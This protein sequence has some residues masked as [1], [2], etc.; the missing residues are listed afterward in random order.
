MESLDGKETDTSLLVDPSCKRLLMR[1][2]SSDPLK[3]HI[4][5]M[6]SFSDHTPKLLES[7]ELS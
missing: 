7:T 6:V 3:I 4:I 1:V 5:P 2:M